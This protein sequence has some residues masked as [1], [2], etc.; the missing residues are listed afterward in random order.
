MYD[1][2]G[3][4][5]NFDPI[6]G[7]TIDRLK[8]ISARRDLGRIKLASGAPIRSVLDHGAGN[9]RF[10]VQSEAVFPG[11]RADA[12]DFAPVGPAGLPA[13]VRYL[14]TAEF[15]AD[16]ATYDLILLRHVLEHTEDP[17]AFL[18]RLAARLSP[19]GVI[20]VEVPNRRSA[21]IRLFGS[22]ANAFQVPYHLLHFEQ[23]SFSRVLGAAGL[24]GRIVPKEMP[25]AGAAIADWL[26]QQRNRWHQ[27]AGI[28]LEPLQ[29]PST[30]PLGKP[31][32]SVVARPTR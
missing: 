27:L 31:C 7:T 13:S 16:Q 28:A 8:D 5:S 12:V 19:S 15:D 26:G 32:L 14:S 20:Y 9:G 22:R 17:V 11:C 6:R 3:S 30:G 1:G 29:W 18:G 25:L 23:T 4:A 10:A 2:R 24:E 21:Y